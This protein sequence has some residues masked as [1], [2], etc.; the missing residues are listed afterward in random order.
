[1][2]KDLDQYLKPATG[3]ECDNPRIIKLA[4]E[5]TAGAAT[6]DEKAK[7]LFEWVRDEVPYAMNTPFWT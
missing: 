5:I 7:A 1:M 4:A 6:D 3:I 2:D